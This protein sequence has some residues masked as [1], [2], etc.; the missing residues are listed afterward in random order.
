MPT[1]NKKVS[2]TVKKIPYKRECDDAKYYNSMPWRNLRAWYIK[3]HPFCERCQELGRVSLG[4]QVHHII[5]FLVGASD[6]E[7][8]D[9][10]LDPDNLQTLCT[11]CHHE[12]HNEERRLKY[13]KKDYGSSLSCDE[14]N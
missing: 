7:R 2:K 10:L 6:K 5:P 12:I 3:E 1:I 11:A 8:W 14:E 9:L 4:E 13:N